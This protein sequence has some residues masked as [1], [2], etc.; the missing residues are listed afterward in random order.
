MSERLLVIDDEPGIRYLLKEFLSLEGF[1]VTT[2]KNGIDGLAVL[3]NMSPP[4]LIIMDLSMPGLSGKEV[5]ISLRSNPSTREIPILIMTASLLYSDLIPT[6]NF[7][8]CL[9]FKPYMLD[10]L[11]SAVKKILGKSHNY[12]I[13]QT[14]ATGTND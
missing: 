14:L 8:D 3:K 7:Y 1:E 5:A 11:L 2:A 4:D 13:Q 9:I 12:S 6:D 10:D